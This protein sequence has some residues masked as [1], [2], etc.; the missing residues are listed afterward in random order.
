MTWR[1]SPGAWGRLEIDHAE[2]EGS[3][4]RAKRDSTILVRQEFWTFLV[5]FFFRFSMLNWTASVGVL[6]LGGSPRKIHGRTTCP[7]WTVK[8]FAP[9][10]WP[11]DVGGSPPEESNKQD[12]VVPAHV[13][14]I[15]M[16]V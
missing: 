4:I 3:E 8:S 9:V 12:Q 11:L 7:K 13:Q 5:S 14:S 2:T 16:G 10:A 1:V 6:I 15:K